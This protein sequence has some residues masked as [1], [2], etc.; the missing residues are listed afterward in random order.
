MNY[1]E[2]ILYSLFVRNR[3][4]RVAITQYICRVNGGGVFRSALLRKFYKQYKNLDVGIGSYSWNNDNFD[5][6]GKIGAFCSFG[7]GV[8]RFA[9][10][11]VTTGVT[12]HPC[13]FNPIYGWVDKDPRKCSFLTIG[14]DVW[15][16]ANTIILPSCH[17]IGNG[18]IVGAGSIVTKDIPSYEIWA[19]NP[20][21]FIKRRFPEEIACKLDETEWWELPEEVLASLVEYFG[22]PTVF[23]EKVKAF[24]E[25]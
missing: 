25:N 19:G 9:L 1:K 18:V 16:G 6:L 11:H 23:I 14:H 5:G 10:N 7:P 17:Q 3:Y 12:S 20:A 13:W 2:K 15:I 22:Q 24:K 21:K 8:K 4:M